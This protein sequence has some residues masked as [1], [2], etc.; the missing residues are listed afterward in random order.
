MVVLMLK[1]PKCQFCED[2]ACWD[3]KTIYGP[4]AYM[5]NYHFSINGIAATGLKLEKVTGRGERENE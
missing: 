1:L 5:C 3:G 2:D 4:W